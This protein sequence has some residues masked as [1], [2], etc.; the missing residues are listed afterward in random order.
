MVFAIM[1]PT[2]KKKVT[3]V[4]KSW[5]QAGSSGERGSGLDTCSLV[6]VELVAD[7]RECSAS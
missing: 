1:Q 6:S 2:L 7:R 3:S 5:L 4:A